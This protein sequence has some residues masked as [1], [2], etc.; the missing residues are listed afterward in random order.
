MLVVYYETRV[1]AESVV[2]SKDLDCCAWI[3]N[4]ICE[5]EP[6]WNIKSIKIIF[7]DYLI[8]NSLLKRLEISDSCV[9]RGD[10]WYLMHENFPKEHNFGY[11]VFSFICNHL[12]KNLTCESEDE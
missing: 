8:T 10:Y 7:V 6:K 9:L 3:T 12:R 5:I 1:I 2:L 4:S 11:K